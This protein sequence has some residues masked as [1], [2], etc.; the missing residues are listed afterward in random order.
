[1]IYFM[2]TGSWGKKVWTRLSD[3]RNHF[4]EISQEIYILT[5]LDNFAVE[6]EKFFSWLFCVNI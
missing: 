5:I 6:N 2:M 3:T 4:R 1:M